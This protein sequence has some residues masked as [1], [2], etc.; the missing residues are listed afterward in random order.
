MAKV[1]IKRIPKKAFGGSRTYGDQTPPGDNY[2]DPYTGKTYGGNSPE[3]K[4]NETLQPTT[5]ENATLEAELGE[6]VVTNLQGE[7]IPEFY[8]IAGKPHSKGGTPL[9]LPASSFIFSKDRKLAIT[10]PTMLKLFGRKN[11][12]RQTPADLSKTYNLNKFREILVN[13]HTDTLQR[14]TA[15]KMIKNYNLKLGALALVQESKKGFEDNIPAIAMGYL[16]KNGIDPTTLLGEQPEPQMAAQPMMKGG[17]ELTLE[18]FAG[19]GPTSRQK[20][21]E[22]GVFWNTA[23]GDYT[24]DELQEGD[25]EMNPETGRWEQISLSGAKYEG[26]FKDPNLGQFSPF[27]GLLEE[28]FADEGVR[29]RFFDQYQKEIANTKPNPRTGL[30]QQD[31]NDAGKLD[32]DQVI[33]NFLA[34]ERINFAI[35]N[36]HAV[37]GELDT[38]GLYD[39]DPNL[40]AK[41]AKDLGYNTLDKPQTL[42]FQ[43]GYEAIAVLKKNKATA[44][45]W[46]DFE[47]NQ[48]G[49][50]SE[51]N[52]SL[53]GNKRISSK[54]GWDGNDTTGSMIIPSATK[55]NRKDIDDKV[56][57]GAIA[58]EVE[59]KTLPE[60]TG[61]KSK[62]WTQDLV[63]LAGAFKDRYGIKKYAPWQAPLEHDVATPHFTD[64]R[65]T[66]ARITSAANAGVKQASTFSNPQAYAANI[67][68]I[69]KGASDQI[70]KTQE[71]EY[72]GNQ[73]IAN[74]FE[75]EN[76]RSEN[77]HNM[78]KQQLDTKLWDKYT[79]A[80]QQFDNAKRVMGAQLRGAFN[81]AWTN[82]GKT[83]TLNAMYDDF[84]VDP[85]TGYT[86]RNDNVSAITPDPYAQSDPEAQVAGILQR[87]PSWTPE[88]AFKFLKVNKGASAAP[89]NP[90]G[91]NSA[92]YTYPGQ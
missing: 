34:K 89:N 78:Q 46:K 8:K 2:A 60:P 79:M 91:V 59:G 75:L 64:F 71:A 26:D 43:A 25:Y 30:T 27:Y 90:A 57:K 53:T 92:A 28:K 7:G 29:D 11:D 74:Q 69:Q 47:L 12:K 63:N 18:K 22:K 24:E 49:P 88:D 40:A 68:N 6:T 4:I 52:K 77:R 36:K 35:Q 51:R 37:D 65:G 48:S 23:D 87:N 5:R 84:D 32:K 10:D 42:A 70:L 86:N 72:R 17:G 76:T 3:I 66:A 62:Y 82:K 20:V 9:N 15:E 45:D 55:I 1:K 50:G 21:N 41:M 33:D 61:D 58:E 16:E 83:Q 39:K 19:G 67:A 81:T 85:V 31:I 14:E 54:D 80:N 44:K 38:E 73:A 56:I 13:P